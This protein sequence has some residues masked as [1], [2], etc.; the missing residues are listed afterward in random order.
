MTLGEEH[1]RKRQI[2]LEKMTGE[3]VTGTRAPPPTATV[4][5]GEDRRK[6]SQLI[7][8]N[9]KLVTTLE[10]VQ[11]DL[12]KR[13]MMN[14]ELSGEIE[15][16]KDQLEKMS[17][18]LKDRKIREGRMEEENRI[19]EFRLK[20]ARDEISD[21]KIQMKELSLSVGGGRGDGGFEMK[22]ENTKLKKLISEK[23]LPLLRKKDEVIALYACMSRTRQESET[24]FTQVDKLNN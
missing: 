15:Q 9:R 24:L 8:D 3:C 10:Q 13:T 23:I 12:E 11:S 16:L 5:M 1:F 7:S 4:E 21:L 18:A 2:D 20:K 22:K 14:V 17:G 6:I 19:L